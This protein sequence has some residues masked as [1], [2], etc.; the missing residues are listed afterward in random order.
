[1][2]SYKKNHRKA[3]FHGTMSTKLKILY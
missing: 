3:Y 2:L 1:L